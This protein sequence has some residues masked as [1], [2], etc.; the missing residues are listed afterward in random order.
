MSIAS[1]RREYA[2]ATLSESDVDPDPVVQFRHWF[3]DATRADI[4][5]PNAMTLATLGLDG[6]PQS[7]IVL[8]KGVDPAG[9]TF[10]TNYESAKG[11][12]LAA[13]PR[14][15]LLFFWKEIE[16]QVRISGTVAR[17]SDAESDA[18]FASRPSGSRLGA[19]A[20]PQSAVIPSRA[21]LAQRLTDAVER[22]GDEAVP[23]PPHWGGY[24]LTPLAFEFWQGRQ[25]RLHDRLRYRRDGAAWMIERLAP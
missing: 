8:L 1:L 21:T 2:H 6:T 23:R 17:A 15:S 10:F 7:R 3:D 4:L 16:R 24:R 22:F 25:S 20:S 9:F 12:E 18:Y 19:W 14:A 13:H 5:E 11:R